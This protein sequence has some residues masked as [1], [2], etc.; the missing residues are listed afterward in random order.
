MK[1]TEIETEG[2]IPVLKDILPFIFSA[3]SKTKV[4]RDV[5]VL[6]TP[7]IKRDSGNLPDKDAAKAKI[8]DSDGEKTPDKPVVK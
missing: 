3:K 7:H 4:K 1:T 8:F 2:G 6:L 5:L